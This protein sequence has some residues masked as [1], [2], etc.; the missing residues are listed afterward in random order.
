MVVFMLGCGRV[1]Y[2]IEEDEMADI[3]LIVR[4]FGVMLD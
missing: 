1:P 4:Q 2:N 3:D